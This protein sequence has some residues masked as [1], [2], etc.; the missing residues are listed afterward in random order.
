MVTATLVRIDEDDVTL[1]NLALQAISTTFSDY[2][3]PGA[4]LEEPGDI[5]LL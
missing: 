5:Y 2:I 3:L 1:R 4:V